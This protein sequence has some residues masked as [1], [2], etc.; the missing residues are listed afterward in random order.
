MPE[1]ELYSDALP[2]KQI[3]F[4]RHQL[5]VPA[6]SM[7][8]SRFHRAPILSTYSSRGTLLQKQ[9]LLTMQMNSAD[10]TE[11]DSPAAPARPRARLHGVHLQRTS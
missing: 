6:S 4:T 11:R 7:I 9:Q 3:E 1:D 10:R 2:C 5:G 8:F